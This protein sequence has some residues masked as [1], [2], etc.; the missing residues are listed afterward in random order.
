M[1]DSKFFD[2]SKLVKTKFQWRKLAEGSEKY[3]WKDVKWLR[4]TK[5]DFGMI[6][7]KNTLS[8]DEPFKRLNIRRRGYNS[9][10]YTDLEKDNYPQTI[11]AEK[12]K[13][14]MDILQF[15][16][17]CF[18]DFYKN[19]KTTTCANIHPDLVEEEEGDEI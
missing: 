18:H 5:D 13:D 1:D 6:S 12:K 16:D 15:I 7:F 19:L 11:S 8:T 17:P 2:F 10:K 14:L 3:I 4:Y 9:I